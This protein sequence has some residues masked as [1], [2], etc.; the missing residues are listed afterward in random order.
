MNPGDS[1]VDELV[2]DKGGSK[3]KQ[4]VW[5]P[6][7]PLP[8]GPP[9]Q[10]KDGGLASPGQVVRIFP[11]QNGMS[12]HTVAKGQPISRLTDLLGTALNHPVLDKTGLTGLYDYSID[13]LVDQPMLP[14]LPPGDG[15]TPAVNASDPGP[16][17]AAAVEQQLGLRLVPA[18][19][20]IDVLI[21][22]KA[23]KVPTSN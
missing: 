16:D 9:R 20:I 8:P 6:A 3:L 5:D 2:I 18:K 17:I 1:R 21:V 12:F 14:A 4:T 23:I 7:A 19:A 11:R 10:D 22:D 15:P 13:Y